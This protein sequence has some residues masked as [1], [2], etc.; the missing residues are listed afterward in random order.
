MILIEL[1]FAPIFIVMAMRSFHISFDY[2]LDRGNIAVN[3]RAEVEIHPDPGY[4]IVRN[5]RSGRDGSAPAIP[6]VQLT[7][8]NSTWVHYDSRRPTDLT[9][10][11]GCA[12][13]AHEGR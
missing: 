4:Y 7:K 6:E 5:I 11:I 8:I 1:E 2:Y 9:L 10:C 12:I 3:L 13:D